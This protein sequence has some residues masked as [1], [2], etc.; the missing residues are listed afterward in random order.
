VETYAAT[1]AEQTANSLM[2]LKEISGPIAEDFSRSGMTED[3]RSDLLED[4]KQKMRAERRVIPP[5]S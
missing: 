4:A 1:L 2:S 5:F 3:E